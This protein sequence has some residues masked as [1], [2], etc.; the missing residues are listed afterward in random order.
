MKKS[1]EEVASFETRL[2]DSLNLAFT[3]G[4]GSIAIYLLDSKERKNFYLYVSILASFACFAVNK[5][6]GEK[7]NEQSITNHR[8]R[9]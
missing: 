9:A 2:K 7:Q 4:E 5:K 8:K 3:K 1:D 6:K